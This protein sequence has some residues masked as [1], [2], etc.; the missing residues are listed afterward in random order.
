MPQKDARVCVLRD[1]SGELVS[2]VPPQFTLDKLFE[3]AAQH[4]CGV[5]IPTALAQQAVFK[6]M[7]A[8]GYSVQWHGLG[9]DP[10]AE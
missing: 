2:S 7:E 8:E 6:T 4:A 3:L 5:Y 9:R 10:L 1:P